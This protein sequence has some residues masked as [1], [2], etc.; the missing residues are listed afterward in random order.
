MHRTPEEQL[1]NILRTLDGA[2]APNTL[3]AYR[4]DMAEFIRYAA[5]TG[6][7][8]LPAE[9]ATVASFLVLATDSGVKSSTIRRKVSAISTIH[10]LSDLPDPTKRS[11]VIIALRKVHRKLGRATKQAYGITA[12]MLERMLDATGGGLRGTRDRALLL[13]AYESLR[14]RSEICSL[15]VEDIE[16]E[17]DGTSGILLRRSKTDQDG[18]GKWL[19]LSCRATDA[20]KEWILKAGVEE[21]FIFRAVRGRGHL[22]PCLSE[23]QISRIYKRLAKSAEFPDAVTRG[24]SGHSLRVGGAQELL[25]AGA[26]L[27]QIMAKGGWGKTDTVMRYVERAKPQGAARFPPATDWSS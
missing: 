6:Q 9:P 10:R 18:L 25:R 3:R 24:I 22:T 11:E 21:G 13:L 7:C 12:P 4:A 5:E 8:P 17:S 2:Y 27:P 14:R 19:Y 23:G 15:R 20:L 26:S 1:S 16:W